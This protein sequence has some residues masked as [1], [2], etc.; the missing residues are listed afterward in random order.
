MPAGV[1]A[2]VLLLVSLWQ[3]KPAPAIAAPS[4]DEAIKIID[5]YRPAPLP[6]DDQGKGQP[7]A[8]QPT[9]A[10]PAAFVPPPRTIADITAILDK[11]KP[12][13]AKRAAI[14]AIADRQPPAGASPPDLA[15][16]YYQRGAAAGEL[17]RA[18]QRLADV[19]LA[20]SY[21]GQAGFQAEVLNVYTQ[22]LAFAYQATGDRKAALQAQ[23]S[24]IALADRAGKKGAY[25]NIYNAAV[26]LAVSNGQLDLARDLETR[27]ERLLQD[28]AGWRGPGLSTFSGFYR[29]NWRVQVLRSRATIAQQSGRYADAEA[30]AREALDLSTNLLG[31]ESVAGIPEHQFDGVRD[32]CRVELAHALAAQGRLVEAEAQA[33]QALLSTLTLHGRYAPETAASI[34]Q[35]A[36]IIYAQGRGAEAE[37]L[38][39]AARDILENLGHGQ[40]SYALA[41][42]RRLIAMAQSAQGKADATRATYEA[43][44][45]GIGDNPDLRRVFL[46]TNINYAVSLLHAQ[47]GPD[48]VKV[49]EN[50]VALD[51]KNLGNKAFATAQAHGWLAVAYMRTGQRDRAAK[52]FEAAIPVLT[53]ASRQA[54]DNNDDGASVAQSDR[55]IQVITEAYLGYLADTKGSAAAAETFHLA[56]AVRGRSVERALAASA[57]RSAVSDPQLADLARHEQD[58]QKQTAALQG[59]L[60][61]VLSLPTNEQDAGSVQKLRQQIDQLRDARARVREEIERRFPDYAN[62]IDPRPATIEQ[63]QKSL[64]P[65]EALIATYVGAQRLFVW[66]VP[67]QGPAAFASTK[68]TDRDVA[69]MV[70]DLRK[71]LDPNA[72]TLDEVPPFDVAL[73]NKLY[74]IVLKPVEAGWA[75]AQSLLIVPHKALG[76]IPMSLLVTRPTTLP[77]KGKVLFAE[78]KD[79]P[80]LARKVAVAQLP[81]VASLATL[82]ALPAPNANRRMFIGFGDP[83][84]SPQEAKEA[85]ADQVSDALQTRGIHRTPNGLQT[86]GMPLHRRSAP[87]T[88]GVDSAQLADLPRLP[89]TAEEVRSIALALHADLSTDVFVG[90]AANEKNVETADLANRRIIV[91][92]THGLVPGDLNG[93]TEP[94]LALSAPDVAHVPGDGLLTVDKILGLKLNADWVVLSACNTASGEG[95]GAEAVSGLGRAFFY[96]GTRALLVSNWPVETVSARTLTTDLFRRQAENP[97]L[98]R[99][100]ALRQAELAL[101]DG[102]GYVDPAT[103]QPVFSYAHP[104]F[105]APFAVVGDGGSTIQ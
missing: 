20:L 6:A 62:L 92:A 7:A 57:A 26:Q 56:E 74:D 34:D 12:D 99:S 89:D 33:R 11:Q 54:D 32:S 93:L 15:K 100:E 23:L 96:A 103:K 19:K 47:R 73:A 18:Q 59:L 5:Q 80:F 43:L 55:Q 68:V 86:R 9:T 51:E 78:Y 28:S 35:L 48:A 3:A 95:A 53:S 58:A 37:K 27:M 14:Q 49:I 45:R 84:F 1:F 65:G 31:K 105:W 82:R 13:P 75:N 70:T 24:R 77:P 76:Q 22:Q 44:E 8:A 87:K 52:E 67:P 41:A 71:A 91:F 50:V 90:A 4:L 39:D 85:Q 2:G 21:A 66:A 102:P 60:T 46:D 17:G 72:S 25:F 36:G 104:I 40:G 30:A 88:E 16:F 79:V 42:T 64:R 101:I 81:A 10:A 38:A 83:W 61:S 94:A 98:G 69:A 63:A 97:K 29:D